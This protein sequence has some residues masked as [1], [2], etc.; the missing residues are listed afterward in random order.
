MTQQLAG[1]ETA[2]LSDVG[3][4]RSENQDACAELEGAAGARL[5]L[6]AD[7]MGGH[8]GGAT[9]SRLALHVIGELFEKHPQADPGLLSEAF[10][11]A[12]ERVHRAAQESTELLGMGTTCVA[13]LIAGNGSAWVAHVGDSRAY[14]L[15][16]GRLERLTND[17][18]T[19]AELERRGLI[20]PEEAAVHP[21]R[22][23]ILR[24]IGVEPSVEPEISP[25]EVEVGDEFLLCTDGLT[26]VH[27][28]EEIEALLRSRPPSEAVRELVDSTL[29]RG[30][31]DNVT[32]VLSVVRPDDAERAHAGGMPPRRERSAASARRVRLLAAAAAATTLLLVLALLLLLVTSSRS[33]GPGGVA[34]GPRESN[35]SQLSAPDPQAAGERAVDERGGQDARAPKRAP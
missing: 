30:A 8:R 7:G 31:P 26:G 32:V 25:V 34:G 6:V 29:A 20:T 28:D 23:E 1:L 16:G 10:A 15:R 11:C 21:R 18:S 35:P 19:V 5:L 13:L 14:R 4:A 12:N 22:N 2:S 17:H 9:A 24:S 27:T 33:S 3:I